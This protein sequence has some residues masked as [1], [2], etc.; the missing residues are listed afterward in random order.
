MHYNKTI[1]YFPTMVDASLLQ[2]ETQLYNKHD[3]RE[4]KSHLLSNVHSSF[5]TSIFFDGNIKGLFSKSLFGSYDYLHEIIM[6]IKSGEILP[7]SVWIE[8][9][10]AVLHEINRDILHYSFDPKTKLT[11]LPFWFSNGGEIPFYLLHYLN[12]KLCIKTDINIDIRLFIKNSLINRQHISRNEIGNTLLYRHISY[13]HKMIVPDGYNKYRGM[14]CFLNITKYSL[15]SDLQK[16]VYSYLC[17]VEGNECVTINLNDVAKNDV[18]K[19]HWC[20]EDI[21]GNKINNIID[22]CELYFNDKV[23]FSGPDIL[24]SNVFPYFTSK[25]YHRNNLIY[26]DKIYS[27]VF[28]D[29]DVYSSLNSNRLENISMKQYIKNICKYK[30]HIFVEVHNT[31]VV[32]NGMIGLRY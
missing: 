11:K 2:L 18:M 12:I 26:K 25:T 13:N 5:S 31:I 23:R 4:K 6:E 30:V 3:P 19:I 32:S 1:V 28:D 21:N 27:I 17:D 8:N 9:N 7:L 16:I 29:M 20:Y 22:N 10:G 14:L 15:P 24:Y